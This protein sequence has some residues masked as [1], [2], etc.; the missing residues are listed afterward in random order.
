MGWMRKRL[1]GDRG[2]V[3]VETALT[4]PLVLLLTLGGL[5]VLWWL[6]NKSL[7]QLYIHDLARERAADVTVTGY[8]KDAAAML[9]GVPVEWGIPRARLLSLHLPADPPMVITAVCSSPGGSVP[10]L[11]PASSPAPPRTGSTVGLPVIQE[12]REVLRGAVDAVHRWEGKVEDALD[13]AVTVSEQL[14]WY[15]RAFGNLAGQREFLR[16]QALDYFVGGLV[17]AGMQ[18]PCAAGG[19]GGK[20]LTAKAVIRGERTFAQK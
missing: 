4:L 18:L 14:L 9:R 3:A 20:V 11:P 17:E 7:M 19:Q 16:R 15:R 13:Q 6:L 2:S 5:T 12:A 8:Y 10:L 1:R